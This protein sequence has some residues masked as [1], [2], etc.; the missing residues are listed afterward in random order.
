[1]NK[2]TLLNNESVLKK[3]P[4][5]YE[6]SSSSIGSV[7]KYNFDSFDALELFFLDNLALFKENKLK[8]K[9]IGT[10]IFVWSNE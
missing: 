1:M 2:S 10:A 5:N 8:T 3:L 9:V 4:N 6:V 7:I